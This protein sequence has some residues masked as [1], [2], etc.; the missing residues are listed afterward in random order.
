MNQSLLNLVEKI[1]YYLNMHQKINKADIALVCGGHDIGVARKAAQLYKDG[2]VRLILASGGIIRKIYT[3]NRDVVQALEADIIGSII[4]KEGVPVNSILYEKQSKNTGEN[5]DFSLNILKKNNYKINRIILIQKPYA[6]RRLWCLAKKRW[7]EMEITVTSENITM[8][9]YF[10]TGIPEKKII[11]M[12]V[13][14]VQRLMYSPLF[15]WI[16]SIEI[17]AD[18]IEAYSNLCRL[19]YTERLMSDEVISQCLAGTQS[20]ISINFDK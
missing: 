5:L 1:W 11:S 20:N 13:G 15:G 6:E 12:M 19:G 17:P 7:P 9:D 16:D 8:H 3:E 10:R 4:K 18:I 14:E 2:Y